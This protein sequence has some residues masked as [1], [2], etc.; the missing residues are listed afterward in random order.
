MVLGIS[1]IPLT[2]LLLT[3]LRSIVET[4]SEGDP[5]V[6]ANAVRL[7]KI[8][9]TMLGLELI[10][11]AVA[12]AAGETFAP[13]T[14]GAGSAVTIDVGSTFSATRWVAVLLLFVL[15]Q[16]FEQGARMREDLAGTI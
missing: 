4:V 8:A 13:A 2:H 10:H 16:V 7:R 5:F 3:H 15:A 9:W 1:A 14:R 12:L 6:A 11:V